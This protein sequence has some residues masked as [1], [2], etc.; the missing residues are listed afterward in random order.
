VTIS[1]PSPEGGGSYTAAFRCAARASNTHAGHQADCDWPGCGCD[2]AASKV[3]ESLLEQGWEPPIT[4]AAALLRRIE[5]TGM[6]DGE[7]LIV[8]AQNPAG[9]YYWTKPV[10]RFT[11]GEIRAA[12]AKATE[13]SS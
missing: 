13:P 3:I 7:R 12:I 2:P 9:N 4:S 11:A 8:H 5:T 6:P 1:T 10:G